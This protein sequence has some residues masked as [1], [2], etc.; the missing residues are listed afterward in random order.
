MLCLDLGRHLATW[1]GLS[2]SLN[3]ELLS[4]KNCSKSK[5]L[6]ADHGSLSLALC[7]SRE[8]NFIEIMY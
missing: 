5:V 4:G 3:A 8:Q 1:L 2:L 7:F 6:G